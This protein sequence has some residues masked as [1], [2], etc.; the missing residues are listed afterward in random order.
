MKNCDFNKR[1]AAAADSI[2]EPSFKEDLPELGRV[3]VT[4]AVVFGTTFTELAWALDALEKRYNSSIC[5]IKIESS[6]VLSSEFVFH[7]GSPSETMLRLRMFEMM[8]FRAIESASL[9]NKLTV[10][11]KDI[12]FTFFS[13]VV[14]LLDALEERG[15]IKSKTCLAFRRLLPGIKAEIDMGI[16]DV[17][18]ARKADSYFKAAISGKRG[19]FGGGE[20]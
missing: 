7:G 6:F 3:V 4:I 11:F 13:P 16:V 10:V 2:E 20:E 9:K 14:K 15:V 5:S 12:I 17:K 8:D 19:K 1:L 18:L